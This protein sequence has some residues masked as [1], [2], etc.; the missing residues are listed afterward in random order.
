MNPTEYD[1]LG[2]SFGCLP[3][4]AKGISD[5]ISNLLDRVDLIIVAEKNCILLFFQSE[6]FFLLFGS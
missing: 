2:I 4:Q 3:G 5:I 1:Y 6:N